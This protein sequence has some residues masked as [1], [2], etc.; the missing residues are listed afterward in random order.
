MRPLSLGSIVLSALLLVPSESSACDCAGLG[1][2]ASIDRSVVIATG[3]VISM[4]GNT[5]GAI[6]VEVAVRE[7]LKGR[8]GTNLTIQAEPWGMSCYGYNFQ[9]GH[10][11]LLFIGRNRRD[12]VMKAPPGS[13]VVYLCSGTSELSQGPTSEPSRGEQLLEDVRK[14]LVSRKR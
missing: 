10:D 11:Y 2:R 8:P 3:R 12:D 7:T 13:Y 9:V 4:E 1:L 14:A 5:W 6:S